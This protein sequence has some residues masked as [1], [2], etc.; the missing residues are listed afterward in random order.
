MFV[1]FN[2][3]FGKVNHLMEKYGMVD[4]KLVNITVKKQEETKKDLAVTI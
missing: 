2:Y 3:M 1:T 4:S